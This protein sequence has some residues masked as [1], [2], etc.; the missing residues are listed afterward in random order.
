MREVMK[1]LV[2]EQ[3]ELVK[4]L[5]VGFG[6]ADYRMY[7]A[8]FKQAESILA[9]SGI[10]TSFVQKQMEAYEHA[11]RK[12]A[13]KKGVPYKALS[14]PSRA[15]VQKRFRKALRVKIASVWLDM[16]PRAAAVRIADS[17]VLRAFCLAERIDQPQA[18]SKSEI[19]RYDKLVPESAIR[20][21]VNNL[22]GRA[23][24]GDEAQI[25]ALGL[26]EGLSLDE[27]FADTTCL[28]ANIHFP[29]DW[30]LLN[31]GVKTIIKAIL[32]I[33]RHGLK[34]RMP[35]PEQFIRGMNKLSMEMTQTARK[36]DSRRNRK[37]VLRSMKKLVRLVRRHAQRYR[38]KL[39]DEWRQTDLKRGQVDQILKRLDTMIRKLPVAS[40]QAHERIIGERA[41]KNDEKLLS[42][43]EADLHVIVRRKAGAEVEFGNTFL[44]GEQSDGLIVDWKLLKDKSPGDAQLFKESIE[45]VHAVF[46]E[47]PGAAAG[48]RGCQSKGNSI[49]M[50]K[51][52]IYDATT[53]RD[54]AK[55]KR[56]LNSCKFRKLQ[57]RRSQTEGRIGI[58]KNDFLGRTLRSKGF[59]N[60][61]RAVAWAVLA[62]NIWLIAR[63][64]MEIEKE[65]RE[66]A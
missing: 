4:P 5:T 15:R 49:W 62:H 52:H 43:Y 22:T 35:E 30:V 32:L 23:V 61:E 51:A 57:R 20:A 17:E 59:A 34:Y 13:A 55:L 63:I 46:G 10:E 11:G 33:R 45:R 19:D 42:L 65:K 21:I 60:R 1:P 38:Q 2:A 26:E 36:L 39:A 6:N 58:L 64:G 53:P 24:Q 56:R 37:K 18:P 31:D 41:V 44:L 25:R 40:R 16:A 54:P 27:Y 48:D 12:G 50:G 29:V 66:A 47:Y 28:R 7:V 8:I 14:N 3:L 9:A